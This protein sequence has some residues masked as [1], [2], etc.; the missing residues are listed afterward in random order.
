ML[1]NRLIEPRLRKRRFITFVMTQAAIA[2]H[3]DHRVAFKRAP[4]IHR[5]A[6]HLRHRFGFV[7]VDMKNRHLQHLGD[8]GGVAAGARLLG[9]CCK[10][11]LV[12]DHHM[13]HAAD[14]VALKL[15]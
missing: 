2:I 11:N 5:Q 12:V 10:S 6:D 8:I 4:E 9:R 13:Q 1:L 14:S 15:A 7:A 3:I